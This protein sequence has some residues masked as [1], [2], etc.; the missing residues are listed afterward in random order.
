MDKI[1]KITEETMDESLS[2]FYPA[3][4]KCGQIIQSVTDGNP[5]YDSS[6]DAR[7][8]YFSF[9]RENIQ[10]Y[11]FNVALSFELL[12]PEWWAKSR[13]SKSLQGKN[14]E[15][16]KKYMED[17]NYH[18]NIWSKFSFYI[19][20]FVDT[21]NYFR[22]IA[23]AYDGGSC[24]NYTISKTVDNLIK[25]LGLNND[26][27]TLW[28]IM[29]FTRN[30]MHSGGFHTNDDI[31]KTYKT[32]VFEFKK[33]HPIDFLNSENLLFLIVECIEL[34]ETISIH[35]DIQSISQ[36]VHNHSEVIFEK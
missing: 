24:K 4:E 20:F 35:Q 25:Q 8:L 10:S 27:Y 33:D 7:I 17:R 22:L 6:R 12:T 11:M 26:Y 36:I 14:E 23:E 29:A 31:A 19:A 2:R 30:T 9:L 16:K 28:E 5:S 34:L 21:E 18:F 3:V 32:K 15:D 13:F 1:V